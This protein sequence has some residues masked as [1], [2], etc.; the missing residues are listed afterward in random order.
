MILC[1][2]G[3]VFRRSRLGLL[4]VSGCEEG[5]GGPEARRTPIE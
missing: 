3:D 4:F 2:G 5:G 1:R